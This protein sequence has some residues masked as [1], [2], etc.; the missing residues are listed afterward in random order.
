M[1]SSGGFAGFNP[2]WQRLEEIVGRWRVACWRK[3][4]IIAHLIFSEGSQTKIIQ[5]KFGDV[6]HSSQVIIGLLG[7]GNE[8]A[9]GLGRPVM[10]F[11]GKGPQI[12][13]KFLYIQKLLLGEAISIVEARGE[14]VAE[15]KKEALEVGK[16]RRG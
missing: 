11:P 3:R 12:T 10:S 8:Q 4:R 9:V 5:G 6:L 15:E 7:M 2:L 13:K 16:E 14:A 1:M